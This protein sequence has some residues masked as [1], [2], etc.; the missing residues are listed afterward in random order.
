MDKLKVRKATVGDF[1]EVYGHSPVASINGYSCHL[2]GRCVAIGGIY[3]LKDQVVAFCNILE[4][5]KQDKMGL[6]IAIVKV[7][8]LIQS[9]GIPIYAIADEEIPTAEEFLMHCGFE[10]YKR[11]PNGRVFIWK[12]Y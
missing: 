12:P 6:A 10:Y 7:R 2:N 11:G 8:K 3:Y 1:E 9:K 5:A 4:E